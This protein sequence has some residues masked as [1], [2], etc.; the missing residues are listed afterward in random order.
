MGHLERKVE[1]EIRRTKINSAI[2]NTLALSG[3]I[4][5]WLVAPNVVG[6]LHKLGVINFR[7]KKQGVNRSLTRLIQK[8][9]VV[10]QRDGDKKFVRLTE[11]GERYAALL[12]E[13]RM[14]SKKPRRWDGKWRMLIFDIP[15]KRKQLRSHIRSTLHSIGFQRLQ[16][17]VWVYPYDCEDAMNILKFEMKVGKEVLYV[18]A[19]AIENDKQLRLSFSLPLE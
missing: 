3:V 14:A 17:S 4:A 7:Q 6:A 9:Y 8:G 16:D 18:I 12:G 15:E 13:G 10:V 19:D 1:T 11:K 2:I 5:I